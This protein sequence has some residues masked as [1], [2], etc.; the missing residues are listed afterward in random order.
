MRVLSVFCLIVLVTPTFAAK[1]RCLEWVGGYV[2]AELT[3]R[4]TLLYPP[5]A[6]KYPA[7]MVPAWTQ[8]QLKTAIKNRHQITRRDT[9]QALMYYPQSIHGTEAVLA[10]LREGSVDAM[11]MHTES[12]PLLLTI[13]NVGR[14]VQGDD[15]FVE[16][17]QQI[18]RGGIAA[19][20]KWIALLRGMSEGKLGQESNH[21]GNFNRFFG[22][23]GGILP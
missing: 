21:A 20:P 6:G 11:D 4:L 22:M 12:L 17:L 1:K 3:P 13:R 15:F 23:N 10:A 8:F 14:V 5:E 2:M 16:E 7:V 18:L 19:R 9:A